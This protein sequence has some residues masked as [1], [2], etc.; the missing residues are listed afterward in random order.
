MAALAQAEENFDHVQFA[1][2]THEPAVV[3]AEMLLESA[4]WRGGKVFYSDNGS[5]A[6][7]VALKM[8]YQFWCHHGERQRT[9]FIGFEH[10]YHGDTFGAMA[11]SRDPVFFGRFEPLLLQ[12]DIL[13]LDPARFDDHLVKH[14]GEV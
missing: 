5:T 9:H 6:V 1:G 7:E 4:P 11:V 13:P 2:L 12:A 10:G 8:A 3:L 14:R